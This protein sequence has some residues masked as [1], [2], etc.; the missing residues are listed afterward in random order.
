MKLFS[1]IILFILL[2]FYSCAKENNVTCETTGCKAGRHCD[3]EKK[4]CVINCT[5]ES[6]AQIGEYC[7]PTTK[8]CEN[9]CKESGC[10]TGFVCDN[11]RNECVEACT[12]LSCKTSEHCD[13]VTKL[14]KENCIFNSCNSANNEV[15]DPETRDCVVKATTPCTSNSCT[16]G[17][18][19]NET[20]GY[21][22]GGCS[23]ITCETG[24][25][26][27]PENL[28]CIDTCT[29]N[30]C[31][32]EKA[33]NINT[34]LCENYINYPE[35]PYAPTFTGNSDNEA[36][37]LVYEDSL[38]GEI[39]ENLSWTDS[40]N[41][42]ISLLKYYSLKVKSGAPNII[43]LNETSGDCENCE[44]EGDALGQFYRDNLLENNFPRYQIINLLIDDDT[45]DGNMEN[46]TAYAAS[47]KAKYHQDFPSVGNTDRTLDPYNDRGKITF[48][49]FINAENMK[50]LDVLYGSSASIETFKG[51][52]REVEKKILCNKLN[53]ESMGTYCIYNFDAHTAK[54]N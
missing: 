2:F 23:E 40:E 9:S 7:N 37:T 11:S 8:E 21:C 24:K 4:L 54:C 36:E 50:I 41:K 26:C 52:I 33:C 43:I 15:C 5:P 29:F 10:K 35:G 14:C 39:L 3:I 27:N 51:K 19:C 13:K 18:H 45:F 34:G 49:I 1:M 28:E 32:G 30:S 20:T 46:P 42:K 6:C 47:W 44:A 31:E 12:E 22:V 25:V 16:N 53:C 38:K 17:A 48:K